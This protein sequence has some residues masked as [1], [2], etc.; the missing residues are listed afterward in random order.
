MSLAALYTAATGMDAQL[1]K[2][3]NISN[4]LSNIS[5]TAFKASREH[6]EDLMYDQ[7]QTPGL[8][9][10]SNTTVPVGIQIGTGTHLAG[11]YKN[12]AQGD[13][14]QSNRDLDLAI[15]GKG[16]FA[17]TL[18]NGQTAYTRDGN[19]QV[20]SNGQLVTGK[21]L[22]LS[23]GITIPNDIASIAIGKDGTVSTSSSADTAAQ[24]VGQIQLSMFPNVAG[25]K[26]LGQNLYAETEASGTAA[27]VTP[28]ETGSG[29]LLQGS[30][31][32]SNVNVAEELI[33]MIVA[34]RSYEANSR[35]LSTTNEMMRASNN[36]S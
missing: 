15:E 28:G 31:E 4:N 9:S 22:V 14:N 13:F 17:V 11:V 33:N 23:P 21:G 12:H 30:L 19:F 35:V 32:N 7:V 2:I 18:A 6:F 29:T 34:Q 25:L 26:A 20:D 24:V 16:L 36:I 3:N 1:T 5:T 10:D 8:K 27:T